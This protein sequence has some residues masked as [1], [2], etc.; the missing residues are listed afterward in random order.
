MMEL[1]SPGQIY[2]ADQRG[3]TENSV[4]RRY[5]TFNYED[6]QQA[7]RQPFGPLTV[8]NDEL[9][10]AGRQEQ[11]TVARSGYIILLP[12]TG[13]LLYNDDTTVDAGQ[14]YISYANAGS[15]FTLTN[16][17]E[18]NWINF[19]YL[20]IDAETASDSLESTLLDFNFRQQPNALI[21]IT[22]QL[23]TQLPFALHIGQFAGRTDALFATRNLNAKL[24]AFVIAGAF[25]CQGRLLHERDGLALWNL[26]EADL[27]ALSNNAVLLLLEM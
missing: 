24:F 5:S 3:L 15:T 7:H 25:E 23:L 26:P 8:F 4:F 11:I 2:L 9:L 17:Y 21:S 1:L 20:H 22:R 16:P 18:G 14:L 19:L 27:E 12:V 13:E 6:Y 10:A